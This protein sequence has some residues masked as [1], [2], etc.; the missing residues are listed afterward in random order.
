[1]D[2]WKLFALM[3]FNMLKSQQEAKDIKSPKNKEI[4][5]NIRET[6]PNPFQTR[7][8]IVKDKENINIQN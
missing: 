8:T 1:V 5:V 6:S 4:Q 2:D 7:K 3:L